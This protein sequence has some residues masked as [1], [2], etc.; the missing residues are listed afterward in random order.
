[1]ILLLLSAASVSFVALY[2]V[3]YLVLPLVAAVRLQGKTSGKPFSA[4]EEAR[5]ISALEWVAA[6]TSW[7]GLVVEDLPERS[8]KETI[9]LTL[10]PSRTPLNEN[11]AIRVL[12]GL[13]SALVF[14]FLATVGVFVWFWGASQALFA[15]GLSSSVYNYLTGLQRYAYRLL[16]YQA[17]LVAEY[18]PF[19]LSD[20]SALLGPPRP[21]SNAA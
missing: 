11:P 6:T 18:P 5:V 19:T 14:L 17:G 3:A 15:G 16:S 8:A 20:D 9:E 10:D 12:S 4:S 1:L 7:L 21:N 2:S 13:P